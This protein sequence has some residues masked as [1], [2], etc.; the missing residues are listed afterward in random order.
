MATCLMDM[1][2]GHMQCIMHVGAKTNVKR[3]FNLDL[4]LTRIL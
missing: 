4:Q 2:Y 1:A 3:H